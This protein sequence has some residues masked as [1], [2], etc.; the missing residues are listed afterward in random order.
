MPRL[1]KTITR[2]VARIILGALLVAGLLVGTVC[3]LL[4]R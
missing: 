1:E 4:I 2:R 3:A